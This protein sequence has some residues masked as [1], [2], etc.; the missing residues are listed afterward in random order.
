MENDFLLEIGT[1]EMPFTFLPQAI[2]DLGKRAQT[3][4]EDNRLHCKDIQA[5]EAIMKQR[6]KDRRA[7]N[8]IPDF[9]FLTKQG[10]VPTERRRY[11]DRRNWNRKLAG[12][13]A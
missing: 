3:L 11:V 8:K 7:Y 5:M 1:E 10:M 4:L 6:I 13:L 9:P 2:K 12:F